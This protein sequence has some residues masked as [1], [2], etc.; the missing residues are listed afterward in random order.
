MRRTKIALAMALAT[1]AMAVHAN[2][3]QAAGTYVALGDSLAAGVGATNPS[4]TGYVGLYG[5]AL[6]ANQGVDSVHNF[7]QG[8]AT[9]ASIRGSQLASALSRINDPTDTTF[10]TIDIGG[11]DFLGGSCSNNWGTSCP[12]RANLAATL[13]D[14]LAALGADP[15]TETLATMAYYNPNTGEGPPNETNLDTQLFGANGTLGISDAGADVGINDV[16]LQESQSRGLPMANPYPAFDT[17]GQAWITGDGIHPTDAGYAAIAQAFCDATAVSC[18]ASGGPPV[19][20]PVNP[21]TA[22]TDPPETTI[23]K[24]PPRKSTKRLV[25]LRFS[26]D[27]AGSTFECRFDNRAF[28]ACTSPLKTKAGPG[29]HRFYVRAIDAAGNVDADPAS[30]RFKVKRKR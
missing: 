16:I 14:L 22:D 21:P 20:P 19:D 29:K 1:A 3:A 26:S 5:A 7:G 10:V 15:G 25:K 23:D 9:S 12:F 24:A 2:A 30:V 8:G 6:T 27:E 28:G 17:A 4:T 13:D 11:N 18:D